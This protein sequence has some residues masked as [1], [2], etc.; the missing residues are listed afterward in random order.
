LEV[1]LGFVECNEERANYFAKELSDRLGTRVLS[2]L[3]SDLNPRAMLDVD[4]LLTT[5][6]HLAEVRRIANQHVP[7][8]VGIVVA[9]HIQT[10]VRLSQIPPGHRIGILYSTQEQAIG[11]RDSL[12]QAGLHNIDVLQSDGEVDVSRFDSVIVPS[13]MPELGEKLRGRVEVVQFGN[14]LDEAS[15]RMVKQVVGE[16]QDRKAASGLPEVGPRARADIPHG[17]RPKQAAVRQGR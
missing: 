4:L 6:F 9:P 16:I 8:V 7:D 14:M 15:I 10:L 11:I 3:L 5:F 2:M 1:K 12:G 13:E 17:R